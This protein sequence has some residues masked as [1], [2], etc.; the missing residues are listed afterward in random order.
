M[1]ASDKHAEMDQL[2][3]FGV[4]PFNYDTLVNQLPGY[5]SIKD[6]IS[7]MVK[8]GAIIR[9]KKGLFVVSPH[10]S[11]KELSFELIANHLYGPSY[12]S[13]E[14]ALSYHGM[15][16]ER[17]F[18]TTSATHKRRKKYHTP[19][20]D[21]E[22]YSV[23]EE[24]FPIGIEQIISNKQYAFLIASPEKALCDQIVNTRRLRLQSK[25]AVIAY[26]SQNLRIDM[27]TIKDLNPEIILQ[28][29][30]TGY[31]HKELKITYQVIKHGQYI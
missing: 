24:Y 23:P 31:K 1:F 18:Q 17:T 21:F 4:L 25:K 10:I 28:C 19:L 8:R 2:N 12:I 16:P 13:F 7:Q 27:D 20:G 26:L 29:S 30:E 11:G 14:S 3:Q 9:L 5:K 6:K 22:Y 15:I